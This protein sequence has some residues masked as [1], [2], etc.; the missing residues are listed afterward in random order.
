MSAKYSLDKQTD[1]QLNGMYRAPN[2]SAQGRVKSMT[3]INLAASRD[4]LKN[5]GTITFSVQDVLNTRKWRS[6]TETENFTSESEFQWRPRQ[7]I[8]TFS[9]RFNQAKQ[10]QKPSN[11]DGGGDE[12]G[13]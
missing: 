5:K 4:V 6:Y 11:Y 7:F 3:V 8:A 1:I 10:R 2:K 12:G 9:Y 13:F